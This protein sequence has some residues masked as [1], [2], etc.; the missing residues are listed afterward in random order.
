[1]KT[2]YKTPVEQMLRHRLFRSCH[3]VRLVV[4]VVLF[5]AQS[6]CQQFA[7][8][9]HGGEPHVPTV[10]RPIGNGWHGDAVGDDHSLD[11]NHSHRR[12]VQQPNHRSP[13]IIE[14]Q[15]AMQNTPFQIDE[16]VLPYENTLQNVQPGTIQ[17]AQ[18]LEAR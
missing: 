11:L 14:R 9:S 7:S 16:P 13:E 2:S 10:N 8:L 15:T 1:M 12:R 3:L 6:G 4:I 18:A 5:V 17:Q